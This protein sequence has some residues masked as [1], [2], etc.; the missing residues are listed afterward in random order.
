M[1]GFLVFQ[2][3][4]MIEFRGRTLRDLGKFDALNVQVRSQCANLIRFW[5]KCW[6]RKV[7]KRH[8]VERLERLKREA[9]EEAERQ[10]QA[11]KGKSKKGKGKGKKK[12]GKKGKNGKKGKKGTNDDLKDELNATTIG[13]NDPSAE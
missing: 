5:V 6:L 2:K 1:R 12:K 11:K 13:V 10:K 3:F 4:H 8:E 9:E 7:S